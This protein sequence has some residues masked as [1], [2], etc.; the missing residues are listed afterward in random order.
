M[1]EKKPTPTAKLLG[2]AGLIPFVILCAFQYLLPVSPH[3]EIFTHSLVAYGAAIASFLGAI[4][5]GFA[6]QQIVP[7]RLLLIWGVIPSLL[8][9][10]SLVLDLASGLLILASTLWLCFVVDYKIYPRFELA[11]WLVMRFILT[12][13]ASISLVIPIFFN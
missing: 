5:W 8:G 10:I 12:T 4:H 9:W 2:Y 13:V 11:Q 6:M 3:R 7:N 1:L